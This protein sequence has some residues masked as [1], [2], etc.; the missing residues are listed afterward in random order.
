MT[1]KSI[2]KPDYCHVHW[3]QVMIYLFTSNESH[4][5]LRS[6]EVVLDIFWYMFKMR[7]DT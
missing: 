4:S 7:S 3:S 6:C 2:L 1:V 5:K